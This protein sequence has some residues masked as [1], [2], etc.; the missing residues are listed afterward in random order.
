LL[1]GPITKD[2]NTTSVVSFAFLPGIEK[3][4]A[5]TERLSPY[6]GAELALGV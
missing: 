3:H 4:F 1:N 6:V 2:D 5:G